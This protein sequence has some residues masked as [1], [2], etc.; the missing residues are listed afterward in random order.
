MWHRVT[1]SDPSVFFCN[2]DDP[3]QMIARHTLAD[4][5][6]KFKQF[7]FDVSLLKM[8]SASQESS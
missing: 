2:E 1:G 4:W 3:Y 6:H 8:S 5:N 7:K